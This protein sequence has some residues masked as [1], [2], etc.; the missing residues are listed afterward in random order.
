MKLNE[1]IYLLDKQCTI[2]KKNTDFT[3]EK[4][5]KKQV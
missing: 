4:R 5:H 2:D 3:T 1:I